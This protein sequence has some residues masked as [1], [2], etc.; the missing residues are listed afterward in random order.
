MERAPIVLMNSHNLPFNT[1]PPITPKS[2][3]QRVSHRGAH[4]DRALAIRRC[5]PPSPRCGRTHSPLH[6]T[7][8]QP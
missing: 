6:R 5:K 3:V 4:L 7:A 1:A 2:P 8:A